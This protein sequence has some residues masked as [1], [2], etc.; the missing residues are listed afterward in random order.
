MSTSDPTLDAAC[1]PQRKEKRIAVVACLILA[2][3]GFGFLFAHLRPTWTSH[4]FS[5]NTV[6]DRAFIALQAPQVRA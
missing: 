1:L 2:L 3:F 4:S 5:S 6:D